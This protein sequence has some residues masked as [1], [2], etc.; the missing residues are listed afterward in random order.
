VSPHYIG[1]ML[2]GRGPECARLD[3][4]IAQVRAG[5]SAALI[6]TGEAGVGKTSL[7]EYAAAH[8]GGMRVLRARGVKSER[9]LP[10]AGLS[11]LLRPVLGH[12]G[13]LPRPQRAALAGA[14]AIGP[15]VSAERFAVCAAT[16]SLLGEAAADQPVLALVD[17]MHWLDAASAQALEFTARRLSADAI[18]LVTAVRSG[19]PSSF[20]A[21]RMDTMTVTGLDLAAARELLARTGRSIA[22]AVADKLV[23]GTG[24]NPLALLELT[25]ALT[26][27]EL[28][29][30]VP[31]LE[32]LP[33]AMAVQH[34]F[35][36]RLDAIDPVTRW[37]LLLAA[38][39]ATADLATLQRASR[40]LGLDLADL[41]SAERA[42]LVRLEGGT[43]EFTH[44]LLRSAA[45]H[46]AEPE[47][48]QLA[49][50]ALAD[51]IDAER[52]PVRHAWHLAAA[53]VAPDENVAVSLD[54]AAHAAHARNA[55]VVASRA[56]Q[57]AAELTADLDRQVAR[58]M[59]AGQA[60]CLGGDLP[61]A[62]RLLRKV[63]EVTADPGTKADAQAM[64]A[65]ATL[66]TSPPIGQH[67]QLI[68][69]AEAVQPFDK[70]RA[71]ML[72]ALASTVCMMIGRLNLALETAVRA[73][74]LGWGAGGIAWLSSQASLAHASILTGSRAAG[75]R[76]LDDIMADPETGGTDLAF[77]LLRM[78]CGQSLIWCE[79]YQ[80]AEELLSS[81]VAAGRATGRLDD[82]PYGL[83]TLSDLHFRTGEWPLAYA[84]ATEAVEL[85]SVYPANTNLSY[86]LVC[87][88]RIDAAMGA[89]DVCRDRLAKAVALAIPMGIIS[90]SAY[91]AAAS[92]LLELGA[93]NY[94]QAAAELARVDAHVDRYGVRDPCVI[95]WRP[96]YIESLIRLGRVADAREQLAL[97]DTEAAAAGSRWAEMTAARCRGML[98]KPSQRAI[99]Q[100]EEAVALA[101]T[102]ACVFELARARLCLGEALRRFRRRGEAG[103]QLT[104]AYHAFEQLGARPWVDRTAAELA[105]AGVSTIRQ[106]KPIHI[107]LTPQE[108]RVAL[109]VADGL[110][111]QEVAARLFL[112]HKTIEVHLGHIYDKLGVRSRTSLARL[113]HSGAVQQ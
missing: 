55:F 110:S 52:D 48:R 103:R 77:Q 99:S 20:D 26:E 9:N 63:I 45:Y 62:D 71:A 56:Y 84:H 2:L 35:A 36:H 29:G 87:A 76:L 46:A 8:S 42:G 95:Q 28:T 94:G 37:L 86:A 53:C 83:A 32:P 18:G 40:L 47:E 85:S 23:N 5:A 54:R 107:R 12:L 64:L 61:S 14:L 88:G 17:D 113:V 80:P 111:N 1:G 89:A 49:H 67:Q 96:D 92:G 22:P 43:T 73:V 51:S 104:Q 50:R 58:W 97:L 11:D 3:A 75:R 10:F 79:Q 74:D 112:S 7:L 44:P 106:H 69:D 41:A 70:R 91:A 33:V 39:D 109:Q 101:E 30:L 82:L 100:L 81:S 57:R 59:A 34:A 21:A 65:Y 93:G 19:V 66:W 6:V 15:A 16:L 31:L 105:T 4:L 78:R 27:D 90:T 13:A 68:S 108:L 98:L 72:L 24:G 102:S 25:G 60:A 38:S